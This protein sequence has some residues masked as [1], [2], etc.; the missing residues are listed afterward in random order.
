LSTAREPGHQDL[1]LL[2][3]GLA[4]ALQQ[5]G[6]AAANDAAQGDQ[7]AAADGGT[8]LLRDPAVVLGLEVAGIT[9]GAR[10][11]VVFHDLAEHDFSPPAVS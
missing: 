3:Q 2:L 7:P 9:K 11:P 8:Q 5:G 10:D 6:L 1:A 4:D